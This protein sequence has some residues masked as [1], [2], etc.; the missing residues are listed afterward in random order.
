MDEA[1]SSEVRQEK[2]IEGAETSRGE[3]IGAGEADGR[4]R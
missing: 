2:R 4:C 3:D 1:W